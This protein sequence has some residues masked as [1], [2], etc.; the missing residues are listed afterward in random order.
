MRW[1]EL[2]VTSHPDA[3]ESVSE[4][5]NRYSPDG[6][7]I[8]QPIELY[9]EGQ[10]YR[11]LE[12]QPVKLHAY[13]PIDG[14]EEDICLRVREAL[15]HFSAI[16]SHL[17]GD[18]ETRPV[19]EED[20]ANAWKEYYHVTLIGKR[21]VIRPSW[22]D[23]T[24]KPEEVVLTLDPGMAFGTGLH[25]TTRMCLEQL[26]K[27]VKPGMQVLDVGTGSGILAIAA[28]RLG[29]AHVHAIDNSSVAAESA[30]ENAKMNDLDDRIDVVLGVLDEQTAKQ[31]EGKYDLVLANIIAH[32]IGGMAPQLAQTLAPDGLLIVSGIIEER[33]K[34]AE[35]PL[36]AAGLEL[37]EKVMMEDWLALVLRKRTA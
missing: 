36:Y 5:L 14:T 4:L 15:W 26:E 9:E 27:R 2:T 17:V 7:V 8:E 13:V 22:R 30:A 25:P 31:H 23:Y 6:V 24:P 16:G 34:D 32:V 29:A 3:V 10:A 37:V 18:L 19:S 28:A 12:G 33:R 21:L 1:L 11:V 35:E 20:W